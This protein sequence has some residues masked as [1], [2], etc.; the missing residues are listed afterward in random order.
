MSRHIPGLTLLFR[1]PSLHP[2]AK[3]DHAHQKNIAENIKSIFLKDVL[4]MS[5][6]KVKTPKLIIEKIS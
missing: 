4:K 5:V 6:T 2:L 1:R 3:P